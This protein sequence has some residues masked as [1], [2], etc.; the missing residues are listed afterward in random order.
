MRATLPR[1]LPRVKPLF[2]AAT[3]VAVHTKP[4]RITIP[5]VAQIKT[6]IVGTIIPPLAGALATWIVG[7]HVLAIF[8]ISSSQ[9]AYEVTQIATF[10]VVTGLTWLTNHHI[11][12]ASSAAT[13]PATAKVYL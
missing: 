10:G 3:T 11:L 5:S 1:P 6:F 8:A 2:P 4:R 12:L 9:I 13:K 7:T